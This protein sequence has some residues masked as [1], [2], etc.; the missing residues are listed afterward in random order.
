VT[1][2]STY[3][4]WVNTVHSA[5]AQL[6]TSEQQAILWRSATEAYGLSQPMA[7]SHV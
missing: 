4:Q 3:D 1:L 5:I 6:S 2:A 7:H